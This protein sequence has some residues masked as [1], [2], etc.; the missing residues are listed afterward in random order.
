LRSKRPDIEGRNARTAYVRPSGAIAVE[1]I[2]DAVDDGT[3][4]EILP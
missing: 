1:E 2:W 3:P 4:I